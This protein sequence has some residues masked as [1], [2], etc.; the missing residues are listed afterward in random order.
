MPR[1][2]VFLTVL[3]NFEETQ[4]N[5]TEPLLYIPKPGGKSDMIKLP[6]PDRNRIITVNNVNLIMRSIVLV[7][8]KLTK[9]AVALRLRYG[10]CKL[11]F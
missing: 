7:L 5:R 10:P 4:R 6:E 11:I 1:T 8:I 9:F 3:K 2:V